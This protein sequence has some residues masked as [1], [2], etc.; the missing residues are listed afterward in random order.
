MTDKYY[1]GVTSLSLAA[2][3]RTKYQWGFAKTMTDK[4]INKLESGINV[5]LAPYL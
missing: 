1:E 3:Q 4:D 5:C 2:S